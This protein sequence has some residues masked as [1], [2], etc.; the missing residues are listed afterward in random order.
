[1]FRPRVTQLVLKVSFHDASD[2][3][4]VQRRGEQGLLVVTSKHVEQKI[5][6]T[7]VRKIN[8]DQHHLGD[9]VTTQP[10]PSSVL[11]CHNSHPLTP[12]PWSLLLSSSTPPWAGSHSSHGAATPRCGGRPHLLHRT[13]LPTHGRTRIHH[14]CSTL[15]STHLHCGHLD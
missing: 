15:Y 5:C 9:P 10:V 12:Q 3:K 13:P 8:S 7:W 2:E 4:G 6:A 1:M 14:H 11:D